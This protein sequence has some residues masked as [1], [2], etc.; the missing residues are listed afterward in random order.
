MTPK[1]TAALERL[2]NPDGLAPGP[3]LCALRE[4][5]DLSEHALGVI[6]GVKG[7]T[8]HAWEHEDKAPTK[9][10]PHL[11]E[12]WSRGA[13]ASLGLN[14]AAAI[15]WQDWLTDEERTRLGSLAPAQAAPSP[16]AP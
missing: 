7:P 16:E 9:A 10:G 14:E 6:L 5:L 12:A 11:I 1:Q 8:V 15:R 4:A 3:R 2:Q 13:A